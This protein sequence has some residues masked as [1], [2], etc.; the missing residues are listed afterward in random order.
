P[1]PGPPRRRRARRLAVRDRPAARS[2]PPAIARRR[3]RATPPSAPDAR[4]TSPCRLPSAGGALAGAVPAGGQL[5]RSCCL[6]YFRE[7]MRGR[8]LDRRRGHGHF[9]RGRLSLVAES[10]GRSCSR[11]GKGRLALP[12][13]VTPKSGCRLRTSVGRSYASRSSLWIWAGSSRFTRRKLV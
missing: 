2:G 8:L 4:E 7:A 5:A 10:R 6:P 11:S 3:L 9:A 13:R 1:A 12:M